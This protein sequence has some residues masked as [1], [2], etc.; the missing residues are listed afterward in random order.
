MKAQEKNK[1]Q[2]KQHFDMDFQ[3]GQPKKRKLKPVKKEKYRIN[4]QYLNAE[5]E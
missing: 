1:K 2:N 3:N 4:N 5:D